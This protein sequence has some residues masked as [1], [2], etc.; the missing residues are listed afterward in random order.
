MSN[1][2]HLLSSFKA[3]NFLEALCGCSRA[4]HDDLPSLVSEVV[5]LHNE[6]LVDLVAAFESLENDAQAGP[7]YFLTRNVF[8][9]ALPN[10]EA[11][12]PQVMRCVLGLYRRAGQDVAA[13]WI[14]ESYIDYCSKQP[15]RA[16]E[17]LATIEAEPDLYADLLSVTLL[18][19]SRFD[20]PSYVSH[21][22]RLSEDKNMELRRRAVF[23]LGRLSWPEGVQVS[24]SAL[25]ALERSAT[26]ENDDEIFASVVK[27]AFALLRQNEAQEARVVSLIE[28]ALRK[29][30]DHTLHAASEVFGF[31][32][33]KLR[34]TLLNLLLLHLHRVKPTNIGTLNN[35]DYG[36]AHLLSKGGVE[37]AIRFLEDLLVAHPLAITMKTFDNSAREIAK[38]KDLTSKTATRWFAR[39]RRPLCQAIC[40]I[41]DLDRLDDLP[42]EIDAS[43]LEDRSAARLLLVARRAVG[44]LFPRQTSMVSILVSLMR[45]ADD[46]NV[47]TQLG[48]LLF[49]P[50]LLNFTG[51]ARDYLARDPGQEPRRVAAVIEKVLEDI[52]KYL[53]DLRS[54]G[55]LAALHPGERQQEIYHRHLSSRMAETYKAAEAASVFMSLVSKSLI[56]YGRK[57]VMY[58]YDSAGQPHRTELLLQSHSVEVPIPRMHEIDPFGLDFQLRIF[59]SL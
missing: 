41:I 15:A 14:F 59:R 1:R 5:A 27:S 18:A 2:D 31:H 25:V 33:A 57:S 54:V 28:S 37:E 43:E 44:Y 32:T 4:D 26:V 35:V 6:G 12:V 23:A 29:G 22:I 34:T 21:A 20:N 7:D 46:D 50:L 39:G 30:D 38:S 55:N 24:D 45:I 52:E 8:E 19:G 49:D 17:A 3:G 48:E 51:K 36:I 16:R 13:G 42:L 40:D 9:R 10:L 53:K 58:R 11:A 47:L 56:L